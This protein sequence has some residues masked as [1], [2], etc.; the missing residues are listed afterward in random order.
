LQISDAIHAACTQGKTEVVFGNLRVEILGRSRGARTNEK[1]GESERLRLVHVFPEAQTLLE[2][3]A[4]VCNLNAK[5]QGYKSYKAFMANKCAANMPYV[6]V[7]DLEILHQ[8]A[9]HNA[10]QVFSGI[11]TVGSSLNIQK[12]KLALLADIKALYVEIQ[13]A[14]ANKDPYKNI[15]FYLI[16]GSVAFVAYAA[17]VVTDVTCFEPQTAEFDFEWADVCTR[18]SNYFWHL[19]MAVFF[20]CGI[21]FFAKGHAAA[22]YLKMIFGVLQTQLPDTSSASLSSTG[23]SSSSSSCSENIKSLDSK[24]RKSD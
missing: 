16:P 15:E 21:M 6:G 2:A 18:A 24:K 3:T 7:Q 1:T 13:G 8:K 5:E 22:R 19:Y 11:A 17:R 23:S 9:E 20:F 4:Y 12:H 14:N 10:L